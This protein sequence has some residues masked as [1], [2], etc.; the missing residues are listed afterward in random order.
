MARIPYI[1]E[2]EHPELAA[3]IAAIR[4]R[5]SGD[6]SPVARM[7][8]HSPPLADGWMK[9]FTFIRYQTTFKPRLRELII[10][11]V[12]VRN[13]A[14]YEVEAHRPHALA[15]GVTGA[16][17]DALADWR[18]SEL[19]DAAERAVLAYTDAITDDIKVSDEIFA[20]VRKL[21][22]DRQLVELTGTI[23]AYSFVSRFLVA[24]E[25]EPGD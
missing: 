16:Q 2:S 7:L 1:K 15:A 3:T 5:R 17:L 9:L 12:G 19:F 4:A 6:L 18:K 14:R 11:R 13:G 22:D 10:A 25:I 23:A 24:L 20:G 21:F 8:L